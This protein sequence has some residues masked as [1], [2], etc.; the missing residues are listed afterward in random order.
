MKQHRFY[1][2]SLGEFDTPLVVHDARLVHQW[3]KVL[4]FRPNDSVILFDG[5]AQEAQYR[6]LSLDVRQATLEYVASIE[7]RVPARAVYL[8]WA[9]L[10][11]DKNDWIIQK[12]TEL[13]VTHFVPLLAD[14]SARSDL[15]VS[16]LE[17]WEKIAI[18]AAE[19]CGRSDIPSIREPLTVH[20]AIDSLKDKA[21]F[22][23]CEQNQQETGD[24][25]QATANTKQATS[26]RRHVTQD[27]AGILIGPEGGWSDAEK[28]LFL[29]NNMQ[30]MNLGKFTLRAETA[31]II[32]T[33]KLTR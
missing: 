12:A 19:Q 17:R 6:I 18:E 31:A 28:E 27:T 26:D 24:S 30:H 7:R 32:A 2:S 9:L 21:E 3:H 20:A 33:G 13:G 10:K 14:R 23:I 8:A 11:K 1:L 4:R 25:G 22:Y 16:R 15:A 5:T 29:S